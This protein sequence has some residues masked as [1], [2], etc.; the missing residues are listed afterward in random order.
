MPSDGP[1]RDMETQRSWVQAQDSH[2]TLCSPFL[3][4]YDPREF[5]LVLPLS[6]QQLT[7]GHPPQ[8]SQ[9]R[10]AQEQQDPSSFRSGGASFH[11]WDWASLKVNHLRFQREKLSP[12]GERLA[13]APPRLMSQQSD[14][15][16]HPPYQVPAAPHELPPCPQGRDLKPLLAKPLPRLRLACSLGR[17]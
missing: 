11:P 6:G 14:L 4:L 5:S 16:T 7:G 17:Q 2:P 15:L 13:P 12:T 8:L 9:V 10:R 3:T 1:E